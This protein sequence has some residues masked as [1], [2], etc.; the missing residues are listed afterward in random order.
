MHILGIAMD[1]NDVISTLNDLIE[2]C[3]NGEESYKTCVADAVERQSRLQTM[4]SDLQH[5]CANAATELQDLVR[6]QGG[7]PQTE[8]SD[9]DALHRGWVNLKMAFTQKSDASVLVECERGE[10]STLRSYRLALDRNLPAD[11]RVQIERQ[12]Q[13]ALVNH[14]QI[15]T[16]RN[17][18]NVEA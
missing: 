6:T 9:G 1:K 8:G 4:F 13:G 5:G 14:D 17:Q 3:K 18:L 10:D 2:T 16:L 11:I 12:Y 7:D 15:R